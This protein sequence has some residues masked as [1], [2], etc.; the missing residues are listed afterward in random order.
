MCH[1]ALFY[2]GKE[3][4]AWKAGS[5]AEGWMKR[6]IEMKFEKAVKSTYKYMEITNSKPTLG[7]LYI[8][9]SVFEDKRPPVIKITVEW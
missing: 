5:Y 7:D 9:K 6:D 8:T 1:I 2:R 4:N 3:E